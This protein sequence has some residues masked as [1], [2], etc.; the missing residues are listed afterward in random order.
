MAASTREAIAATI[1]RYTQV[2]EIADQQQTA[3]SH[4]DLTAILQRYSEVAVA[5]NRREMKRFIDEIR[6]NWEV[7]GPTDWY[8]TWGEGYTFEGALALC[9]YGFAFTD[10]NPDRQGRQLCEAEQM[11]QVLLDPPLDAFADEI[12]KPLADPPPRG[13]MEEKFDSLRAQLQAQCNHSPASNGQEIRLPKDFRELMMMTNGIHGAGVLAETAY[14]VLV[15]PLDEHYA[16]PD[17]LRYISRRAESEGFVPLAGWEIGACQQHRQIYYV[18]CHNK[19]DTTSD[20]G[21]WRIFD[22]S[23]VDCN[24]YENLADFLQHETAYVDEEPGGGQTEHVLG[25][26]TYPAF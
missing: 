7:L 3:S 19:G 26:D 2:P 5:V 6:D 22:K 15:Y 25:H 12:P 21:S 9:V 24:V 14:T 16:G 18:F 8:E 23:G 10:Y 13:K 17:S 20:S 1:Q 4:G 11:N